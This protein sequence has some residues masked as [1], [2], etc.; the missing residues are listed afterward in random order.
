M[1][2]KHLVEKFFL[3]T[4][5]K[6]ISSI[7][8][9]LFNFI[10]IYLSDKNTLGLISSVLSLIVFL[11][12]FTKFGLNHATL[13]HSSIFYENN[14]VN[15][16]NQLILNTII[17]SGII[18]ILISFFLIFFE[19]EIAIEIYKDK[20]INGVLKIFALSLPFYTFLQLQKSLFKSFKKPELSNLSDT[21][22]ILFLICIIILFFQMINI[23]I[24]I[25]RISICFL[26]SC[27]FIF[28]LNNF[29]LFFI[30]LKNYK[31]LELNKLSFVK[32][33]MVK[34]LLDYFSIDFVNYTNVWGCIFLCS[35]FYD[36]SEVGI[37]TSVYWLAFSILFFP[38][39]LNSIY[40]PYYAIGSKNNNL[41]KQSKLFHQNRNISLIITTPIF[42][43]LFIFSDFFLKVILDI[44]SYEFN[45]VFK[46][47]LINSFIRIIFG[48]QNLFLNM[49]S[50]EKRL[51]FILIICSLLQ[52][53]L[54]LFSIIFYDLIFFTASFLISNFIKHL[55]LQRV[56]SAKLRLKI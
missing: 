52:I 32:N 28:S 17:I 7:G 1:Q 15:N 41:Y 45:I 5:A 56:M 38:L 3:S 19:D 27:I 42:L 2:I 24:S 25:Y 31:I 26:F 39:I 13:K 11:S 9:L 46:I 6:F 50:E 12:I 33:N 14:D 23:N 30:I 8:V 54:M 49:T 34:S 55:W 18:S 16:I 4:V 21:G 51:K 20:Q 37:F 47:L 48:P 53:I 36:S 29:L 22:S 43:T 10:I 44:K 35:F 40:A